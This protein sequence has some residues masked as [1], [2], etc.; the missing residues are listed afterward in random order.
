M[1]RAVLQ[2]D[3]GPWMAELY[4]PHLQSTAA[5][6]FNWGRVISFFAPIITAQIAQ[7][8]SLATAMLLGAASF[9]TAAVIWLMQR[10]TLQRS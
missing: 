4:P 10:E 6:I 8:F 5:S 1:A 9:T 2:R 3:L 7:S